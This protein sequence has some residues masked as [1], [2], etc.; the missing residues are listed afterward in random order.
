MQVSSVTH[1]SLLLS[2]NVTIFF[3]A[4][5]PFRCG[6]SVV[7]RRTHIQTRLLEP[8][9]DCKGLVTWIVD[10]DL[11]LASLCPLFRSPVLHKGLASHRQV[12]RSCATSAWDHFTVESTERKRRVDSSG[13]ARQFRSHLPDGKQYVTG[14][15]SRTATGPHGHRFPK[16][17]GQMCLSEN[18]VYP[19][20]QWFCWSLSRF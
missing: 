1:T 5:A 12:R 11:P 15:N 18:V 20:T 7:W 4:R 6:T 14:F 9:V 3:F 19:Y 8:R 13:S 2:A 16:S 17:P 10:V